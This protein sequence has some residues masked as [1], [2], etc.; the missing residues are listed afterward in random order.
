MSLNPIERGEVIGC[1]GPLISKERALAFGAQ[2][3]PTC[4]GGVHVFVQSF[5]SS[6]RLQQSS[7]IAQLN[8]SSPAADGRL[9]A[10]RG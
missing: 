9:I 5:G 6:K 7:C 4:R 8:V 10:N 3:V 1:P 2:E